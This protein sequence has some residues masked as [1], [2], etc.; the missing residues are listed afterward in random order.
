MEFFDLTGK[1]AIVTGGNRGIG[2]AI[3]KGLSTAGAK[4]VIANRN[5]DEGQKAADT[6]KSE[7][8]HARAVKTDVSDKSSVSNLV[9]TIIDEFNQVDILVNSAG[10]IARGPV[11]DFTE[12]QWDHIININL[13]GLFFCCQ[14]VGQEMIKR[15]KG[16]IINISSNVSEVIQPGRVVYAVSKAGVSHLTRGLALEWAKYNINVNAIGPGPTITELNKAYFEENPDDL[17]ERIDSIPMARVGY[18]PDHVGAAI[19]LASEASNYVTGQTLL[20]DGG[21]TIW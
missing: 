20:V 10:V 13:K 17:Q 7:G 3:A 6:L 2:Y 4:V 19:Y 12:D 1:V 14:L 8:F 18:P 15:K 9:K 5:A 11:E 16:K 21:S